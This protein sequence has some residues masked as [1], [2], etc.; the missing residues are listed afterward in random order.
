MAGGLRGSAG[1][2]SGFSLE[3]R[4]SHRPLEEPINLVRVR[5]RVRVR[6]WVRVRVRVRARLLG[7]A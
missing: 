6:V 4:Q 1:G 5:V 2:A 7:L 3:V